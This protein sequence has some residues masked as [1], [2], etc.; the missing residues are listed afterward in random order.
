MV[1]LKTHVSETEQVFENVNFF[2][3]TMIWVIT[4]EDASVSFQSASFKSYMIKLF[5]DILYILVWSLPFGLEKIRSDVGGSW[6]C[7]R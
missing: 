3:T 1:E 2:S 7:E 6:F 5:I 4:R